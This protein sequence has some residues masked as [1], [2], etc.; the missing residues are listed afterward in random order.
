MFV[1]QPLIFRFATTASISDDSYNPTV[2]VIVMEFVKLV[3]SFFLIAAEESYSPFNALGVVNNKIIQRPRDT[4]KLAVPATLY[5]IQNILLQKASAN[6]PAALFQVTYQG[7]TLVVAFCS[8]LLLSKQLTRIKWIAISLMAI[9]IA[10]VQLADAREGS[11]ENM[12]NAAEQSIITGLGFVLMGC[13]CSGFAGVYFEKMMK[14]GEKP[15][16][17]VRN[18]QLAMFSMSIGI[19]PLLMEKEDFRDLFHGF[20]SYVWLMVFNSAIGGLC[21]AFVIKYADNILKGFACALATV[22]ATLAAVPLFA[23]E[24]SISFFVGMMIVIFSTLLYGNAIKVEGEYW[25]SEPPLCKSFRSETTTT[26]YTKVNT[27]EEV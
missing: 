23:F 7:K 16:M 5:F 11:Q 10:C 12:A 20:N 15:S 1:I 22:I 8:V 25:N 4:L 27:K 17:W 24:L 21:V 6:L 3:L 18:F 26:E 19:F 13:F 2:A 9:G 14:T